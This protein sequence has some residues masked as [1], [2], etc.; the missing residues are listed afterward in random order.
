V[1]HDSGPLDPGR[2]VDEGD[3][4]EVGGPL[5]GREARPDELRPHVRFD[6]HDPT[7]LEPKAQA[8]DEGGRPR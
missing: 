4:A 3:L 8:L 1:E 7:G 6:L 2:P 5:V